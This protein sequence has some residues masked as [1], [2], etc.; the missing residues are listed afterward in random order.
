MSE[1]T[2]PLSRG[3]AIVVFRAGGVPSGNRNTTLSGS[4]LSRP[5]AGQSPSVPSETLEDRRSARG[6]TEGRRITAT[7]DSSSS[8][9]NV[10]HWFSL[11][12]ETSGRDE[13]SEC[14]DRR[15][16][17]P[18]SRSSLRR[19]ATLLRRVPGARE[20]NRR[21]CGW[22]GPVAREGPWPAAPAREKCS[23]GKAPSRRRAQ[24]HRAHRNKSSLSD[25][26]NAGSAVR[27]P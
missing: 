16:A 3:T 22:P 12:A 25:L 21:A 2:P 27:F 26:V 7:L 15:S 14:G 18:G 24:R 10:S 20:R 23:G 13:C 5:R 1:R 8:D 6:S 19:D 17:V 4:L 9:I 11:A